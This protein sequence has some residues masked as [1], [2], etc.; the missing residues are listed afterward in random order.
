MFALLGAE[1]DEAKRQSIKAHRPLSLSLSL[2]PPSTI[3]FICLKI[4]QSGPS[5]SLSLGRPSPLDKVITRIGEKA[6]K[7]GRGSKHETKVR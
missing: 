4:T 7:R 2:C 5:V 3:L 6:R 1:D